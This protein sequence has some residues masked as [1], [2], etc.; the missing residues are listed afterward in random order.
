MIETKHQQLWAKLE[1]FSLDL[2]EIDFSFSDRLAR[3]NGWSKS[4]TDRVILE[5]KK[6]V[7][8]SVINGKPLTPSDEV[9]QAWHLHL[10][11]SHSYWV[12]MCNDLLG[13]FKLHHG[14]TKGGKE[15]SELFHVQYQRTL[16]TY[17]EVFGEEPP[18][19][20]WPSV[21]DRFK[22]ALFKR[23]NVL[24]KIIWDKSKIKEYMFSYMLPLVSACLMLLFTNDKQPD[25]DSVSIWWW[26][27]GII[28]VL[29]IIRGIVRYAN[30]SSRK[31][32]SGDSGCGVMSS[33]FG[34]S[35]CGSSGCSG[36]GSS[37]CSGCG[38]C[39]S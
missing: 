2:P 39:G 17:R 9:D 30:R 36:C 25:T 11:Y 33:F 8:M 15:Q 37:G 38:G 32:S 16:D 4:F 31:S 22:P 28:V 27:I 10:I 6:F 1:K 20:I 35:G 5:Y 26:V 18:K 34:C 13:G 23:V 7:F 19:D 29:F 12:D 3:E 24:D 21:K 14:P